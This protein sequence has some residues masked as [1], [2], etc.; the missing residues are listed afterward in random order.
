MLTFLSEFRFYQN[1]PKKVK[2]FVLKIFD[3]HS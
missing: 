1:T 2:D 3:K